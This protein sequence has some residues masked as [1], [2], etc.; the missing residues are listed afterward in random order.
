MRVSFHTDTLQP[1]LDWLMT[2]KTTGTR[3]EAVLRRI[4]SM[5]DYQVEFARYGLEGLP[6]C[7]INFEEAVD[8]FLHFDTKDFENPRLQSK[9][10]SFLSFFSALEERIASTRRFSSIS[11]TDLTQ[12]EGLLRNGLPDAVLAEI[13]E[14]DIILI[15]S[16]G[17]SM[18]W[19]YEHYIDYDVA[20][21]NQFESH[22]DFLHVTAHEI[23]HILLG[24]MLGA[25]GIRSEDFFLQNFAFEG[26][27]VHFNNNQDTRMK[28]RKYPG[29]VYGMQQEDMDFYEANF[30][31]I[32]AMIR[33]DYKAAKTLPLEEI[34]RLVSEHYETFTF[35]GKPVKQYPTYYFGCYMW[36]LVDL[37]YGKERLFEAIGKPPLFVQLYNEAAAEKYR[38]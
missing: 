14:L 37:R 38:L 16:I 4:L 36:G 28:P 31:E 12:M 19:P 26:L 3:D 15:V 30:D 24:G 9:K 8:F 10:D 33:A 25:D 6:V 34:P 18:G 17:N 5:P 32:F 23:H 1:M 11:E 7:G 21:L 20:N 2:Y 29:P 35:M 13:D 27:A 22:D